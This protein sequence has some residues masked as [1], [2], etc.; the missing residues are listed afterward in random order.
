MVRRV[1]I[2]IPLL[3]ATLG[4]T[5]GACATGDDDASRLELATT[6][7]AAAL[8]L[9]DR[10]AIRAP[11]AAACDGQPDSKSLPVDPRTLVVPGVNQPGAAIQFNAYWVDLHTPPPPYHSTLAP[12]PRTCGEF[13]ASAARGRSNLTTR[14]Y[15]QPFSTSLGYYG[16]YTLWGYLLRPAD[17]DQQVIQRY[18]LTASP[19]PNPYPLPGEDPNRTNVGSGKLPAGLVQGRDASGRWTGLIS[20]TCSGCHD[21]RLG[22]SAETPFTWGRHNDAGDAGLL[23]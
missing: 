10:A 19:W 11:W 17:F 1:D 7:Q 21:S 5:R 22:T 4:A 2:S 13:R 3:A 20:S 14:A 15:F 8:P 18:G 16:L 12:N 23:Q 9:L 6:S